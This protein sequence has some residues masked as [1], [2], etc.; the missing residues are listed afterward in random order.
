MNF[1]LSPM[2]PATPPL[3]SLASLVGASPSDDF[4]ALLDSKAIGVEL[5][6]RKMAAGDAIEPAQETGLKTFVQSIA[7]S[8]PQSLA[9]P[10]KTAPLSTLAAIEKADAL[11]ARLTPAPQMAEEPALSKEAQPLPP[12]FAEPARIRAQ[13]EFARSERKDVRHEGRPVFDERS[14][15]PEEDAAPQPAVATSEIARTTVE[16][17]PLPL[18]ADM[19]AVAQPASLPLAKRELSPGSPPRQ[20]MVSTT[21]SPQAAGGNDIVSKDP[22]PLVQTPTSLEEDRAPVALP[23]HA[24]VEKQD[25]DGTPTALKEQH[26]VA[27]ALPSSHEQLPASA[28][29]S[30]IRAT[31]VAEIAL[32]LA[33]VQSNP[34]QTTVQTS[35]PDPVQTVT[36]A[37]PEIVPA[38]TPARGTIVERQLDLIR[39]EQWLGELAHDIA[40]TAGNAD[41]LSFRLMP[42]QLGR[43]D[44]DV[45]RSHNGLSLSIRTESDGATAILSAAQTRLADEIRAQGVK[46][47]DT[48]MFSGDARQSPGQDAYSRPAPLIE[49]FLSSNETV[50]VPEP[51]QRDGR[52]A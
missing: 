40:T 6:E 16:I 17:I 29:V 5:P 47:A 38:N 37:G 27:G 8:E 19:S 7:A 28:K 36:Q 32:G 13:A 34:V 1:D 31:K 35:T 22:L 51:E 10:E 50:D 30:P 2:Q 42:H 9:E 43:L 48:Q 15:E 4:A 39:N 23:K 26:N 41:R 24:L 11:V 21:A 33:D 3:A 18:A 49:T 12:V 52:Y 14:D 25:I 20:A 45:S 44:V 46:L